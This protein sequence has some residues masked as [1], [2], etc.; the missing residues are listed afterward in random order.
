MARALG[1]VLFAVAGALLLSMGGGIVAAPATLPLMFLAV[2]RHPSRAFRVGAAVVGGLTAAELAWAL[3]YLSVGEVAVLIWL[4][5]LA[6]ALAAAVLL[7]ALPR[8][9]TRAAHAEAT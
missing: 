3:V 6:A 4:V 1:V 7:G 9:G 5:P 2:R 8:A